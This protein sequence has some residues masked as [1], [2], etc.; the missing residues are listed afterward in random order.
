MEV[1]FKADAW[2]CKVV[3]KEKAER[4]TEPFLSLWLKEGRVFWSG[5][6]R[7]RLKIW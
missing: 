2:G 3:D 7:V 1:R 5:L 4:T 6:V